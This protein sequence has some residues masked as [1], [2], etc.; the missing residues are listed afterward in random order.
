MNYGDRLEDINDFIGQKTITYPII[1]DYGLANELNVYAYPTTF[2]ID[3]AGEIRRREVGA[4]L[5]FDTIE[6]TVNAP[7]PAN[8]ELAMPTDCTSQR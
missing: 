2:L 5:V 6:Q 3:R 7:I 4:D 1:Q 8:V